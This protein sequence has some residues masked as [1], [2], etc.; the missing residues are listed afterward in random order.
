[1]STFTQSNHWC[2]LLVIASIVILT[3]CTPPA[4]RPAAIDE[5]QPDLERYFE[6]FDGALVLYDMK[7][8][9]YLRYRPERCAERLLPAST[10]KIMSALIALETGVIPDENYVIPWD[11]TEY[12]IPEWNRDHS[13]K[14]AFRYSVVWYYQEIARRIGREKFQESIDAAGYGNRNLTGS[15][16]SFWLDGGLRI[17]ADEQVELLRR[18]YEGDLPFSQRTLDTV[19][20]IMI[21][22][23]TDTPLLRGKTGSSLMEGQRIGWF[24]GYQE[25][26]GNV[27][28]FATNIKGTDPAA[29]GLQAKEILLKLLHDQYCIDC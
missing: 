26:N 25:V 24:V 18:L 10:F 22:E 9:R 23:S 7:A 4:S 5:I 2:D 3:A 13:L 21:L 1:V 17:S 6:G 14:S 20:E 27:Y 16:D 11:G 12:D 15:L 19:R 28:F 8:D 29:N